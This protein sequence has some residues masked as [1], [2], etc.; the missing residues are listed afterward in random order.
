ME[1]KGPGVEHL[2]PDAETLRQQLD[3]NY[4][5]YVYEKCEPLWLEGYHKAI[6]DVSCIL[7]TIKTTKENTDE[8]P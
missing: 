8:T 6:D 7:N 3:T 4:I 2:L 1:S 5:K